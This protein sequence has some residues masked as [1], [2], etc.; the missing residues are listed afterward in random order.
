LI[1]LE[2]LANKLNVTIDGNPKIE[3]KGLASIETAD[4]QQI[5]FL[6][7]PVYRKSAITSQAGVLIVNQSD[8]DFLKKES[9]HSRTYLISNNPYALFARVGQIFE[10]AQATVQECGIHPL[11]H[12]HSSAVIPNTCFIGPFCSVEEGVILEDHVQLTSHVRLGKQVKVGAHTKIYP[13]TVVYDQC[14][15]GKRCILHGGV[16]IGSDGFGFA[17]EFSK[18]GGKWLKIPQTGKVMIGNDVEFGASCT[19]DRGALSDT[20]IGEG[21][22]FDNQVQIGHNV[23]IGA[24]TVMAG[25]SGVA[26]S[27]EVGSMCIIGGYSNFSGH[28]KIAD[29][30]MVSGGTSITK[31]ITE[32]G[33]HYTGVFPF[34]THAQW[35]K[36]AAI[37]RGLDKMRLQIKELIKKVL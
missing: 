12:V 16:V 29:R 2:T 37:L 35:E 20:I 22:K 5:S 13:M 34:T 36:N 18:E 21:C 6:V 27:T 15:I 11:A 30:T 25:C 33:S 28:L 24:H 7:N 4:H 31:S 10:S 19:I 3:L 1:S 9:V 17:P 14:Q 32:P 23:K 26:G 8:C